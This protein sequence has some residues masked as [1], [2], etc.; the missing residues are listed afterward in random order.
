MMPGEPLSEVKQTKSELEAQICVALGGRAAEELFTQDIATGASSD[1]ERVTQ[2]AREYVHS[3][4]F[5]E[6]LIAFNL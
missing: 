5:G 4:G 6:H 1:L 2:I 3:Y